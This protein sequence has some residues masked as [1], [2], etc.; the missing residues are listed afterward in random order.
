MAFKQVWERLCHNKRKV[1]SPST[2][3]VLPCAVPA[4]RWSLC[5]L[6]E[7]R[8]CY[9]LAINLLR[10][11]CCGLIYRFW[12]TSL[13]VSLLLRS[14][15][16]PTTWKAHHCFHF[17]FYL[18]LKCNFSDIIWDQSCM[19]GLLSL[20]VICTGSLFFPTNC[21]PIAVMTPYGMKIPWKTFVTKVFIYFVCVCHNNS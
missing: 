20:K 15:H 21:W 10:F 8:N 3:N 5:I 9:L 18:Q 1:F 14:S 17:A 11:H 2:S 6:T 13:A 16:V 4:W 19:E 12:L 7:A